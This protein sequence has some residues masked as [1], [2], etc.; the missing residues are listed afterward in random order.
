MGTPLVSWTFSNL[1]LAFLSGILYRILTPALTFGAHSQG[2]ILPF[3]IE[4]A[5]FSV[6][7][8]VLLAFFNLIPVPPLD[9]GRI[10][11]GLLPAEQA[12]LFSRVE[13]YGVYLLFG[14]IMLQPLGVLDPLWH[15]VIML[16]KAFLGA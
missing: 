7:I 3:F 10:L 12:A 2:V 11:I 15:F 5:V 6:Y 1:S 16:S 8:N 13:Q 4:M 14:L 9:G